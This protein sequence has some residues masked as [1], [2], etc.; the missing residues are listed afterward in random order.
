MNGLKS[1]LGAGETMVGGG[2]RG[3]SRKTALICGTAMLAV[4][5]ASEAQAQCVQTGLGGLVGDFLPLAQGGAVNSLVSVLNTVNTAFLTQSTAFVGAP[6]NPQSDQSAGGVWVRGIGGTAETQNTGVL[7][8][9]TVGGV[10]LPGDITCQTR[11]RQDFAG[12][13]VG[14]DLGRLNIAGS[15]TNIHWGV[16]AGY[17]ESNA[18]DVTPGAGTFK[19]NFQVPF[20]G[21][22][23]ALTRGSFF[24]D[25]QVRWDFYQNRLT[26]QANGLFG[27]DFDARGMS[28]TGNVGYQF[29]LGNGWFVE[30]SAGAVWSRV[31]VD[32]LNVSGT[33]VIGTGLAPPGTIQVG[34]VESFLGRASVRVG[35]NFTSGGVA[36]Q[37]FFTASVFHEFAGNVLTNISGDLG[38]LVGVP[39]TFGGTLSTS[40]VG[41]YGQFAAGIAG[42]ILNTGWLGYGRVDYRIGENIE[43]IS[44][45]AGLRYQFTPTM[46]AA[47]ARPGIYKA[48]VKALPVS[49]GP[50]NWTGLYIGV[51]AGSLWGF[52][53]WSNLDGDPTATGRVDPKTTGVMAGGQIGFNYQMGSFVLGVEADADW[54][55]ANG[56]YSCPNTFFATC[57]ANVHSV[58]TLAGRLGFALNRTMFFAKG[59]AAWS[60]AVYEGSFNPTGIVFATSGNDSRSGWMVGG[61]FEFG[62]TP[63]WSAKAEYNFMDFGTRHITFSNAEFADIRLTVNTVKVGVNYRFGFAP[64]A[65]AAS[66]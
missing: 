4:F 18:R 64:V 40:R 58:A 61:G 7:N 1:R 36:W 37:P 66:Y 51:N 10:G 63:N 35:T 3:S 12:Y 57:H 45:N 2:R 53:N 46:L 56:A 48:P 31:T 30:P 33:F 9:M 26:D 20:V 13:Q 50:Y 29:Q 59:G 44:V 54:T 23:A 19:G 25:A 28:V 38:P 15:G 47:A 11:T 14:A 22:Y 6:G 62:L 24:A 65:V 5:A 27:Q 43:G 21:L 42:Q 32:P 8:N 34:D 17:A 49:E 55:N 60:E 16:T 39:L 52:S 41:T